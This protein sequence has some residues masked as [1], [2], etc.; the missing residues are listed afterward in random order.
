MT[1]FVK[2]KPSAREESIEKTD[3]SHFVVSVKEPP[4][5]GLANKAIVRALAD[6]FNVPLSGVIITSGFASR[7]KIIE[8]K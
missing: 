8:I 5:K 4:V 7:N 6:Y 2:A 3:D 1:I